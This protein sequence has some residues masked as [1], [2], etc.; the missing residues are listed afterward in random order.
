VIEEKVNIK[1]WKSNGALHVAG[2]EAA[3]INVY[4]ISGH[5]VASAKNSQE[6]QIDSLNKGIYI[7]SA[8]DANGKQYVSK[9]ML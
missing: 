6:V 1:A 3:T 8:T 2:I 4:S 9:V 7:V 5:L